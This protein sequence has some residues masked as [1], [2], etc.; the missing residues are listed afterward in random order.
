MRKV[1]IYLIILLAA[2]GCTY[3][4]P[5]TEINP[6]SGTADFSKFVCIGDNYTAGFMDGALYTAGQVNSIGSLIAQQVT[7]FNGGGFFQAD[8]ESANGYNPL[9][10]GPSLILGK[11][12]C[13]YQTITSAEPVTI[14]LPGE[15]P[16]PYAGDKELLT[17]FSIPF[18][19]SYQALQPEFSSNIYYNRIATNPGTSTLLEQAS[20]SSPTF[21]LLWIGMYDALHF[22]TSGALGDYDPPSDPAL[23]NDNDL[24]PED[25]FESSIRQLVSAI[26]NNPS[27]LGV[28]VNLP[29]FRDLPFFYTYQ[30][31]FIRLT[32]SQK[33]AA[34]NYYYSF[35]QAVIYH[36]QQ[37]GA[38]FRPMI[39]FNDNG[40][41][42][43]YPQPLVVEDDSL[44]DAFD[45]YGNP[46]PK[47]RQLNSNEMV[48]MT[49]PINLVSNGLGWIVPLP[50]EYYLNEMDIDNL[51]MAIDAYNGIIQQ[52]V[53]EYPD[54][55]VLADFYNPIKELAA[56]GRMNSWGLPDDPHI[57]YLD[58]IPLKADL[59]LNSIFSLDGLHFN[60]RGNAY[61]ASLIIETINQHF[62]STITT[63]DVNQYV[64]NTI[65]L[66]N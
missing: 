53:Q 52:L 10:S 60:Q 9:L 48:L 56:T 19:K 23:L 57:R 63:P 59:S 11:M 47:I 37:P 12:I 44:C 18:M 40:P 55:L 42:T 41:V 65:S 17:E 54:R 46:I 50:K 14:L 4:F 7:T 30:Y 39:G 38:E 21:F 66:G 26:M 2:T 20:A 45:Q 24:T 32:N 15:I 25:L 6:D 43:L 29:S 8:I 16:T 49:I 22:A 35:N 33:R 62:N 27:T 36:N 61:A 1:A 13:S 51:D 34:Q 3:E 31:D 5:V 64:G 58:G 28:I